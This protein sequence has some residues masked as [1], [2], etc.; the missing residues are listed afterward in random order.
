VLTSDHGE[1]FLEHDMLKHGHALHEELIAVP[2]TFRLPGH[3]PAIF[4]TPVS[5]LDVAPTLTARLGIE[6]DPGDG[7][8]LLARW[9]QPPPA[10]P[11]IA[12]LVS[13]VEHEGWAGEWSSILDDVWKWVRTPRG[14]LL[15]RL[16]LDPAEAHDLTAEHP[17][18]AE[19]LRALADAMQE[20]H[21]PLV[22]P[23]AEDPRRIELLRSLG[24]IR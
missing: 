24:Y 17:E 5:L 13:R 20:D 19:R 9:P 15:F 18:V 12:E 8:D 14:E 7:R 11:V 2:L 6:F 10:A 3:S 16:D 1:E 22:A 21:R 4:E 23:V